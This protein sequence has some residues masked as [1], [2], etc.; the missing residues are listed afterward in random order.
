[1]ATDVD[2]TDS[3]LLE[4]GSQPLGSQTLDNC[5]PDLYQSLPPDCSICQQIMRGFLTPFSAGYSI[6]L[7][8]ADVILSRQCSIHAP[9]LAELKERFHCRESGIPVDFSLQESHF[10]LSK[11]ENDPYLDITM[12]RD[13]HGGANV[14]TLAL[15][16]R[17]TPSDHPGRGRIQ[18]PHWIDSNL[19]RVWK[20]CCQQTHGDDCEH[21]L[22][23]Y[24][25][26][27]CTPTWLIDV[28]NRCLVPG[29][30]DVSYVALSYKW[31]RTKG[32]NL[33]KALLPQLQQPN[34]LSDLQF[35]IPETILNAID[36]VPLLGEEFL[37]VDAL[38]I[39]QDDEDIKFQELNQMAAIYANSTVTVIAASGENAE[40]GLRGLQGVSKARELNEKWIE[41]G[42]VEKAIK[43]QFPS[44][45]SPNTPYFKRGWTFQEYVFSKRRLI[46]E[47]EAMR[48]EC[49]SCAWHEDIVHSNGPEA[50]FKN[51]MIGNIISGFPSLG[52]YGAV[53]LEYN[54]RQF[55]YVE[56]ALPAL[57]G[58]LSML[59]QKYE[60]GFLCGLPEMCFEAGLNWGRWGTD[61][62]RRVSSG[63]SSA[64]TS[65]T[66][67]PS[68]S[69]VGWQGSI[70]GGW[71]SNEDFLKRGGYTWPEDT[72]PITEWY[73][74]NMP[75]KGKRRRIYSKFLHEKRSC[76]DHLNRTL[77]RGWT[78][79][80]WDLKDSPTEPEYQKTT[81][82]YEYPPPEGCGTCFYTHEAVRGTEFWYPIPIPDSQADIVFPPQTQYLFCNTFRAWL[83][84]SFDEI[85]QRGPD[86]KIWLRNQE[87]TWSGILLLHNEADL[88][89]LTTESPSGPR[90]ELVAISRGHIPNNLTEHAPPELYHDKLR[91]T[92]KLYEFYNVLWIEWKDDIAYRRAH[93]R[94]SR[95]IWEKHQELELVALILG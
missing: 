51:N 42:D 83:H 16:K 14:V 75:F 37:W 53:P 2:E 95:D 1:M 46:F 18:E 64:S 34:A 12:S 93:G 87:G 88:A 24:R 23:L 50:K 62:T 66:H 67:L 41:F 84:A 65:L 30:P 10:M 43:P 89:S 74:A 77:P 9:L 49:N 92:S 94:V 19:P 44:Y 73:T 36:I 68:W 17:D 28:R 27:Q 21:P 82:D 59:S 91:K 48:W 86:L 22:Q 40:Y 38:C 54:D 29:R 4:T 8:P 31:G 32:L 52:G 71:R 35:H 81:N 90:I 61:L 33:K 57:T 72:I 26:S 6:D 45:Y 13:K 85:S 69:W 3:S 7:G 15:V 56:D 47:E 80:D 11:T 5:N 63:L 58:L 55:T 70:S 79:H 25:L 39:A 76:K 78:R 20:E 60:G